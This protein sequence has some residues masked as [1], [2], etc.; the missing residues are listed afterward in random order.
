VQY[1]PE[2]GSVSD[3]RMIARGTTRTHVLVVDDEQDIAGLIKHGLEKGGDIEVEIVG[4]GDGAL[5]AVNERTPDLIVLDL[6]LP[7]LSGL[8]VCRILRSR[9]N[10]ATVPIIML[11]ARTSESDRVTGLDVGADDY[12]TKP[13]SLRELAA[14]VRAVLR[15]GRTEATTGTRTEAFV[16]RGKHLVADFDAVAISVNGESIRLTRREFEL[17]RYLV[18]NRNRVLSRDRL[19]ERVWGYDR[20]VETRSVDVHVGRLRGKLRDAG[21]QIETVVGLGY[22]FVE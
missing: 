10:T 21:R 5:K 18:E 3:P 2:S 4:T 9:P 14:R 8:E 11:T 7:V 16:Y 12:I 22:R 19:L 15:R 20:F 17:L 6:N 13:F 1:S